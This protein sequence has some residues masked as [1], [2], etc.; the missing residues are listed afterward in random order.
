MYQQDSSVE[1]PKLVLSI[2]F[3]KKYVPN[4]FERDWNVVELDEDS[5]TI[6]SVAKHRHMVN[7]VGIPTIYLNINETKKFEAMFTLSNDLKISLEQAVPSKFAKA[8]RTNQHYQIA[9]IKAE[10]HAKR[11]TTRPN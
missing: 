3:P 8:V 4:V 7:I 1:K 2:V 11:I 10:K 9:L 6:T 5:Y